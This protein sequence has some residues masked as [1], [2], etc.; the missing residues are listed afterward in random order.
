MTEPPPGPGPA[1]EASARRARIAAAGAPPDAVEEL[2]PYT[3]SP[4]DLRRLEGL[5]LPLDDEPQVEA[6]REYV[7]DAAVRGVL[8]ALADRL[9]Q[10]RF[11]VQA[12]ISQSEEYRAAT[13]RGQV[14]AGRGRLELEEPSSLSL[15]LHATAAGH[16]PI[17]RVGNRQDFVTLVQACSC[18]NEPDPIPD[19][20]GACI[21]VGLN[22]WDRVV[23]YRRRLEADRGEALSEAQWAREL[24]ALV[25]RKD[26][27]QD[28]FIILSSEPYSAVPAGEAGLDEAAW[29]RLSV[30]IR[31]EHECTHYFTL[32]AFGVMRNHLL[33][34]LVADFA[35]LA[36]AFGRYDAAHF[37][38]FLGL[39]RFPAIRPG[40]RFA[41]Y[42]GA[43]PLGAPAAGIAAQ[44]VARA[45][46]NLEA[47]AC[48]L[49]LRRPDVR[50]GLVAALLGSG[51][52]ELAADDAGALLA[53]R[54]EAI[55]HRPGRLD[56]PRTIE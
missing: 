27:Y 10:L 37:L 54:L 44:L 52:E 17:L 45:A 12:G 30:E 16:V 4:F 2:V 23:R 46:R 19:S 25:P 48:A 32:R 11:P 41:L 22:D 14:G 6:W 5:R 34:E 24:T 40:A 35:G 15:D 28:R 49:D 36:H 51:L 13:R 7:Q 55:G 39:D 43:P 33:D 20:M 47:F 31:L 3:A 8:P 21:V 53:S 50:A 56:A 29:R 42:L 9:V 1:A 26:L 18:R 38:R